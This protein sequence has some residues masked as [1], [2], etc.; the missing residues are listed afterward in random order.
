MKPLTL[1]GLMTYLARLS[2]VMLASLLFVACAEDNGSSSSYNPNDYY[3]D[4]YS[5]Q[6]RSYKTNDFVDPSR[7]D[8]NS[9]FYNNYYQT[10]AQAQF[11][12]QGRVELDFGLNY[13]DQCPAGYTPV[14]EYIYG[15]KRLSR[16]D[17]T[18][19][20]YTDFTFFNHHNISNCAGG[21]AG[22]QRCIPM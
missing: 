13:N 3:W 18:G 16:C 9:S 7:C 12:F 5:N 11:N 1:R 19:G 6:C 20:G 4:Q 14:F 17:Y 10:Q 15:V 21:Y 8:Q 22:D 2:F